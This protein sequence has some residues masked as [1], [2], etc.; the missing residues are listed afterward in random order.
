MKKIEIMKFSDITSDQIL[1][2]NAIICIPKYAINYLPI[3][4]VTDKAVCIE[5]DGSSWVHKS[6]KNI[7]LPI[8][9][10]TI[11]KTYKMTNFVDSD[12]SNE[13]EN[14]IYFQIDLPNWLV[15]KHGL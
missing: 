12:P 13:K 9:M 4:K 14:G 7:W 8:S 15:K 5:I 10:I 11:Q 1:R 6:I 2:R 3:V